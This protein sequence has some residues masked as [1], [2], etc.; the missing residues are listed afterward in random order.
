MTILSEVQQLHKILCSMTF[1]AGT[2]CSSGAGFFTHQRR[3]WQLPEEDEWWSWAQYVCVWG[4][5]VLA[6]TVGMGLTLWS[7]WIQK[8]GACLFF[9]TSADWPYDTRKAELRS[10]SQDQTASHGNN[11]ESSGDNWSSSRKNTQGRYLE[12]MHKSTFYS[13]KAIWEAV[14]SCRFRQWHVQCVS[15]SLRLVLSSSLQ[16]LKVIALC[17]CRCAHSNY[18][19][20]R[21]ATCWSSSGPYQFASVHI[22]WYI[23]QAWAVLPQE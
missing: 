2:L 9:Q 15:A 20:R 23:L 12:I 10:I 18:C 19:N 3:N 13:C 5:D 1:S 14:P 17:T 7:H 21:E 11:R 4:N 6:G 22:T 8:P 16:G